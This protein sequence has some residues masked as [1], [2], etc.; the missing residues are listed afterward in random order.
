M[1]NDT[2]IIWFDVQGGG[3][4]DHLP[5]ILQI[6]MEVEKLIVILNLIPNG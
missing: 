3:E 6:E 4:F 2:K 5:I 1:M